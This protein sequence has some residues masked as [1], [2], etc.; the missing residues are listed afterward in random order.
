[1][2]TRITISNLGI[3]ILMI[4]F[5]QGQALAQPGPD[6]TAIYD[7]E[8]SISFKSITKNNH[9]TAKF[10]G[11]IYSSPIQGKI[12]SYLKPAYWEEYPE[13][14]IPFLNED[15]TSNKTY[16]N[17]DSIQYIFLYD[18]IINKQF[19]YITTPG[20]YPL[21]DAYPIKK[22]IHRWKIFDET[23]TIAGFQC[24]RAFVY[25]GNSEVP[26]W[27]VWVNYELGISNGFLGLSDIPGLLV[28]AENF[29][30]GYKFTLREIKSEPIDKLVFWPEYLEKANL[31][32]RK[33]E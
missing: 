11:Y 13:G 14:Y 20:R 12:I 22:N 24:Y 3:L 4:C 21:S 23:K 15:N 33:S 28:Q 2:N 32:S 17:T 6:V 31:K 26:F 5:Y 10:E 18:S 27:E 19:Y 16:L 8:Q 1:M 29:T 7:V 9:F 30:S 25:G